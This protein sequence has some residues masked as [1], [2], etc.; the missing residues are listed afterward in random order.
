MI[1]AIPYLIALILGN[2]L[3]MVKAIVMPGLKWPPEVAEQTC[4]S[5][6]RVGIAV[7]E[8]PISALTTSARTIPIA[9]AMP[10]CKTASTD[11][12]ELLQHTDCKMLTG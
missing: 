7:F 5:M 10:I 4:V 8:L 3:K 2:P 6:I 12:I 1:C 9:Y 11:K